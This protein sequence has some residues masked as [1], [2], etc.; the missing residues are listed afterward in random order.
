MALYFYGVMGRIFPAHAHFFIRAYGQTLKICH[1]QLF[2]ETTFNIFQLA[3][4]SIEGIRNTAD[5]YMS[6]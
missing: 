2:L 4:S 6:R 1:H 5:K 3:Y